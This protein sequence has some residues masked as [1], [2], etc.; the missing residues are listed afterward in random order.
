MTAMSA[1]LFRAE[2]RIC[3]TIA[4]APTGRSAAE[5]FGDGALPRADRDGSQLTIACLLTGFVTGEAQQL[6]RVNLIER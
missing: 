6:R 4:F 5:R 2:G 1:H 3:L